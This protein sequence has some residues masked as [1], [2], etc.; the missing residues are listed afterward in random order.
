[1]GRI[2]NGWINDSNC[3]AITGVDEEDRQQQH[4]L[5]RPE[6]VPFPRSGPDRNRHADRQV[7][8]RRSAAQRLDRRPRS[9]CQVG[10]DHRDAPIRSGALRRPARRV[11]HRRQRDRVLGAGLIRLRTS[12]IDDARCRR[13][14]PARR[15]ACRAS[16]TVAT[17]ARRCSPSRSAMSRTRVRAARRA[18]VEHH[19]D[20]GVFGLDGVFTSANRGPPAMRARTCPAAPLQAVE[21]VAGHDPEQG[22][23]AEQ[24][25][26]AEAVLDARQVLEAAALASPSPRP[27]RRGASLGERDAQ[28]TGVSRRHRPGWRPAGC[29]CRR[30]E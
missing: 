7:T 1:M 30:P 20:L 19:L 3:E 27:R 5:Q 21:V 24:R 6:R 9:P 28:A 13:C 8:W 29:R 25:R 17:S 10:R 14:A 11:G 15:S 18:L 22:G 26:A 2:T 16:C 12:S 23:H 4:E